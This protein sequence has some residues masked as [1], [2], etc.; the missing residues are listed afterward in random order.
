MA[1]LCGGLAWGR[2]RGL[3]CPPYGRVLTAG[4]PSTRVSAGSLILAAPGRD[5]EARPCAREGLYNGSITVALSGDGLMQS[6]P[7]EV[8]N[9]KECTNLRGILIDPDGVVNMR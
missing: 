2:W 1:G 6:A 9:P 7:V 5:M 3:S 4:Y 8:L